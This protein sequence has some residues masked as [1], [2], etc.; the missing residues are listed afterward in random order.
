MTIA[1][2]DSYASVAARE[3]DA[4]R[5]LANTLAIFVAR[6]EGARVWD[7]NGKEYLDFTSGIGVLNTGRRHPHIV[8]AVQEQLGHCGRTGRCLAISTQP[9]SLTLS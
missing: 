8:R 5:G 2:V 7:V 1:K 9:V 3:R 4:P 6:A